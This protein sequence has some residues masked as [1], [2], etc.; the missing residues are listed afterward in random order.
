MRYG[1][2]EN[3]KWLRIV[4]ALTC[5]GYGDSRPGARF[6]KVPIINRVRKAV[7]VYMQDRSFNSFASNM[8]KLSV[9]ETKWSILLARTRALIFF[10]SIWI[11]DFGPEKL[12]G[13][14]RNGPQLLPYFFCPHGVMQICP[15]YACIW[16]TRNWRRHAITVKSS[17]DNFEY[18]I[19]WP[20]G[21]LMDQRFCTRPHSQS[22]D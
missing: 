3:S 10:I 20:I 17:R 9:N 15:L 4:W 22:Q 13:L 21:S 12:S 5:A 19:F 1:L 18:V 6:S 11:F 14:W 8:I 7:V 2:W 16:H